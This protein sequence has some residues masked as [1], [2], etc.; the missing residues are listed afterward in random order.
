MIRND[1]DAR[2][3]ALTIRRRMDDVA[4]MASSNPGL[5]RI[6]TGDG[7]D[8]VLLWYEDGREISYNA[9][10]AQR[11]LADIHRTYPRALRSRSGASLVELPIILR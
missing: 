2:H 9:S 3:V 5:V 1:T 4:K 8:K 6:A 11:Q 10:A 7:G